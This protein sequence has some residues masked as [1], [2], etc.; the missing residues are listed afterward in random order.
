MEEAC[1]KVGHSFDL[2]ISHVKVDKDN[3]ESVRNLITWKKNMTTTDVLQT[4]PIKPTLTQ[5]EETTE[6]L[7]IYIDD[8]LPT[9]SQLD[10]LE[11]DQS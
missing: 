8:F 4:P 1:T 3:M 10:H 11:E 5:V 6:K 7:H 9:L 2:L